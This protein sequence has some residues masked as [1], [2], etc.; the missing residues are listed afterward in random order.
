MSS[1]RTHA[2]P[3]TLPRYNSALTISPHPLVKNLI[4]QLSGRTK[5]ETAAVPPLVQQVLGVVPLGVFVPGQHSEELPL[6]DGHVDGFNLSE[7]LVRAQV[8]R[9][10]GQV[11]SNV[12]KVHFE[13]DLLVQLQNTCTR[14]WHTT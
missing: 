2:N 8:L 4:D 10:L 11:L 5:R 12:D 6:V 1:Q 13:Q 3:Q 14:K 7:Q 9:E